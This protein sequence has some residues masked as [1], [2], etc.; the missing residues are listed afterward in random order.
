MRFSV[1]VSYVA[2]YRIFSTENSSTV[3]FHHPPPP[4]MSSPGEIPRPWLPNRGERGGRGTPRAIRAD[5]SVFRFRQDYLDYLRDCSICGVLGKITEIN[6]RL[7]Y[8]AVLCERVIGNRSSSFSVS[9]AFN[10]FV[11]LG[12]FIITSPGRVKDKYLL[13]VFSL[14]LVLYLTLA[15]KKTHEF[16]IIKAQ[17]ISFYIL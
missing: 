1:F 12:I 9:S 16:I 5:K 7:K 4:S 13:F 3:L 2:R 17:I 6:N 14:S 11:V 8:S 15:W 10:E